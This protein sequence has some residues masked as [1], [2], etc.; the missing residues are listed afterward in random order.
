MMVAES[1][2]NIVSTL[3][4]DLQLYVDPPLVSAKRWHKDIYKIG[5][6]RWQIYKL[7]TEGWNVVK[8]EGFKVLE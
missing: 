3:D 7:R 5:T 1:G 4:V 6:M 8:K 2:M